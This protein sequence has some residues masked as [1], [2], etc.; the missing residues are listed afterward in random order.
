MVGA[1]KIKCLNNPLKA[2]KSVL[3]LGFDQSETRLIELLIKKNY[4]VDH[5]SGLINRKINYDLIISFGYRHIISKEI[6]KNV[7]CPIINLHIS[8]LPYNRGA[9]PNFWSFYDKTPSGVTIHLV[10]EGIDTGPIIYQK[11][12][13]FDNN[14]K[15][16]NDTYLRLIIELEQLF[17]DNL[18]N[19]LN[20]NWTPKAQPTKGTV[21]FSKDLPE[22]FS[23]WDSI[24][25]DEIL[26]L[27]KYKSK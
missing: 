4:K 13:N 15:T 6:I 19:I 26:R 24:I 23:G 2:K 7:N 14:E 18:F 1:S 11:H 9:H 20:C 12:I 3:F 27:Y 17:E 25:K 8:Y 16:F 10:N 22:N 21:H 5:L